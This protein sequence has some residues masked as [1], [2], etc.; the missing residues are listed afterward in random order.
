M[1]DKNEVEKMSYAYG[2]FYE[3]ENFIRLFISKNM[4]F[5]YGANWYEISYKK[6]NNR[7]PVKSFDNLL[8]H[9]LIS[10][11]KMYSD[12]NLLLIPKR[13]IMQ[14]NY[15]TPIRNK[16]AHTIP[17][18][19]NEYMFLLDIYKE[20]DEFRINQGEPYHK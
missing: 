13:L 20:L 15:F 4:H 6:I 14:L 8:F 5:L 18:E 12:M 1:L 10:T 17:L 19:E 2:R 7:R 11:L 16:I 9:E 3:I